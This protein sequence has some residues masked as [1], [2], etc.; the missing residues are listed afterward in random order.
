MIVDPLP[1]EVGSATLPVLER[2]DRRSALQG[3]LRELAVVEVDVAQD[4]L[5]QV[6]SAV[7]AMALQDVLDAAVE[8]LDH[9]V[10]LRPH[11]WREAVLDA[12]LGAEQ[13]EL[14]LSGRSALAQAEQAV[15]E[16]L[17]VARREEGLPIG[18]GRARSLQIA[19][20]VAITGSQV[21]TVVLLNHTAEETGYDR[22]PFYRADLAGR[23]RHF[24]ASP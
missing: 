23:H 20:R 14:V 18:Y 1:E 16:G 21:S 10:R 7:E 19:Q 5:L 9:A 15:G 2:F 22:H 17:A 8:P 13:V 24:Q 6:L 12:Q 4:G 11:R 3:C